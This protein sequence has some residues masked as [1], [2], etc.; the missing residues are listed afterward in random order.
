MMTMLVGGW[1]NRRKVLDC[2][3]LL[4]LVGSAFLLLGDRLNLTSTGGV[5]GAPQQAPAR[6]S[7]VGTGPV[8][9]F[10]GPYNKSGLAL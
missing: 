9:A 3:L 6:R 2:L 5:E 4:F 8:K 10:D 7:A 1:E